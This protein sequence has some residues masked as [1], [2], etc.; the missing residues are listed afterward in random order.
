VAKSTGIILAAGVLTVGNEFIQKPAGVATLFR[1]AVAFL[2]T[3]WL[4]AGLEKL[5]EQ[6]AVGLA[7]IVMI[8][9]LVGGVN[10]DYR[11][12]AAEVLSLIG[13]KP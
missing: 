12:P 9:V 7:A 13:G 11:S 3:A 6:A 10:K 2:G 5:D 1:P 4:F 8:T